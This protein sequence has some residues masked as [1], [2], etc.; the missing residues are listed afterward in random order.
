MIADVDSNGVIVG[1]PIYQ[2]ERPLAFKADSQQ[3]SDGSLSPEIITKGHELIEGLARVARSHGAIEAAGI[4]TEIFR[5]APNGS[6]FLT[7]VAHRTGV[8]IVTLSQAH[9]ARLG[10]ATAEALLGGPHAVSAGWD[11]GGG[12]F[13]ITARSGPVTDPIGTVAL[14]TYVGRLGTGPSFQRLLVRVQRKPYEPTATVN[15]ASVDEAKALVAMLSAELSPPPSWLYGASIVA[16]GGWNCIFA[17]TLRAIRYLDGSSPPADGAGGT[18]TVADAK[19]AL[20]SVCDKK[21]EQ[22][23]P[24]AGMSDEAE[25]PSF[26]VPKIALLVAVA[27]HLGFVSIEYVPATGSAAGLLALGDFARLASP[28]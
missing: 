17:T 22:L 11:S 18:F 20:D 23:L 13:Q 25:A 15:P 14:Q 9:E 27:S 24:I 7:D 12:S 21:D 4:A 19:R 6:A 3:Q 8:P 28:K 10:L 2:T 1:S 26:V 5:T 16:I